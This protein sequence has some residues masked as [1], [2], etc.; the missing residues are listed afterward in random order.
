M[1]TMIKFVSDTS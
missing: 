1:E